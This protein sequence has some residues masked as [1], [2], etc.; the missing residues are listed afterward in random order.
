MP[1]ADDF[2]AALHARLRA[3]HR[4]GQRWIDINSGDLH[5]ALG[6]YPGPNHAMANCCSVMRQELGQK[7]AV[8]TTPPK[9][10]AGASLTIR[11]RLPR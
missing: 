2:R 7:D 11:Y 8:V 3:G 1:T 4:R 5:R 10:A 6:G 9:G